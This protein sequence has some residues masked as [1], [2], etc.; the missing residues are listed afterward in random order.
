MWD[1]RPEEFRDPSDILVSCYNPCYNAEQGDDVATVTGG[2]P[3]VIRAEEK[4][5]K[6][7][8]TLFVRH[9]Y[10][11]TTVD[12]IAEEAGVAVQTV[13]FTFRHK[14]NILK[15]LVDINVAG[16]NQP[17]PTLERTWM[18]ESIE[19]PDPVR[20]L[21]RQIKAASQIYRRV[22]PL[23]GVMAR[24][25]DSDPAAAELWAINQEQRRTVQ[26]QLVLA[27]RRKHPLRKGLTIRKAVDVA[28]ATLGPEL[29]NLLV[30]QQGWSSAEWERWA[31]RSLRVELLGDTGAIVDS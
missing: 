30:E 22:A 18:R 29:Y 15:K 7:A 24:A 28:Y 27:L 20:Q 16:D 8:M 3:P 12:T 2:R 14:K 6:A 23:L 1:M 21:E 5:L 25:A 26:R 9:G 17:V 10:S 11:V 31:L 13:Y 4:I 19:E